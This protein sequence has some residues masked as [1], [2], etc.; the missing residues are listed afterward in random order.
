[1]KSK[2]KIVLLVTPHDLGIPAIIICLSCIARYA[3]LLGKRAVTW[4]KNHK[5]AKQKVRFSYHI[6]MV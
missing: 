5:L 3:S 4:D 1:M 2:M 6:C